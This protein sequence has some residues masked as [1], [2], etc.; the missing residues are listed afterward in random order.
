MC[1][2]SNV[3]EVINVAIK[4]E[5]TVALLKAVFLSFLLRGSFTVYNNRWRKKF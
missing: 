2:P 4:E 3:P 5:N 1:F